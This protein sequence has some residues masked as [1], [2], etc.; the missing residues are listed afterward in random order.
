MPMANQ[1]RFYFPCLVPPA[2]SYVFP[3]NKERGKIKATWMKQSMRPVKKCRKMKQR[4]E[5]KKACSTLSTKSTKAS[6]NT[7]THPGSV[8]SSDL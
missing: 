6:S 3:N 2:C 4:K 5:E 7:V 1:L 8:L